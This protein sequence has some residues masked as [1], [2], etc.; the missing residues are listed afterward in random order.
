MGYSIELANIFGLSM[1]NDSNRHSYTLVL[2]SK[3]LLFMMS[4]KRSSG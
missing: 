1:T 2:T 3:V 4:L